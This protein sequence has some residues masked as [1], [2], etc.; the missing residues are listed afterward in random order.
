M[1]L[2]FAARAWRVRDDGALRGVCSS[3]CRR[4]RLNR[5]QVHLCPV[6]GTPLSEN[7]KGAYAWVL[8]YGT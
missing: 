6:C 3:T 4:M 2:A 8:S 7:C 5:S 1:L